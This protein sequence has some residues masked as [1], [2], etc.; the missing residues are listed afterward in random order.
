M[1]TIGRLL[2]VLALAVGG[3]RI[4]GAA[5]IS[6]ADQATI[7]GMISNQID[8]F[9]HDDGAAA[10]GFASPNIQGL[11]P[12]ADLFMNMVRNAYKPVYRPQSVT[13]GQLSDSPYGPL[14]KVFLV[15]PDG[16]SYVAVY[17]LQRQPD[18]SW[19]INGCTLV[20]DSGATI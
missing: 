12:N 9:R 6:P 8:A 14:Q 11:Y 5:E 18:G 19:R 16:K 13:F 10:Y 1:R 15:G 4:A 17:S 7:Q 20:E 3:P 2:F